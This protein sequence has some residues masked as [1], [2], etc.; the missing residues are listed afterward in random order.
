LCKELEEASVALERLLLRAQRGALLGGGAKVVLAGQPNAGKSSL[1]NALLAEDRSIV[2]ESPGTTR[3][4]IEAEIDVDG[5][6]VR[7]TDTAG[8]RHSDDEVEAEGVRRTNAAILAADLVLAVIDDAKDGQNYHEWLTE[9]P[10][11]TKILAIRNKC[12]ITNRPYGAALNSDGETVVS[13]SATKALGIGA[14]LGEIKEQLGYSTNSTEE[15]FMARHR[16]LCALE[17]AKISLLKA[18]E[19][20]EEGRWAE[21]VAED[22]RISQLALSEILG[23]VTNEDLLGEIF[24][25]FCVGK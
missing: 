22:L 20:A 24:A 4:A 12:D 9:A 23:E 1:M 5:L 18:A 16:H 7:L 15:P 3:D 2:H 21:L 14:L 13:I 8:L 10:K 11:G 25:S 19:N 6:L 17:A